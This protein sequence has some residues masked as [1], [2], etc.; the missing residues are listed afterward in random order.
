V[1]MNVMTALLA[2]LTLIAGSTYAA[3]QNSRREKIRQAVVKQYDANGNG[4]LDADEE[5]VILKKYDINGDGELDWDE[6]RTL[7]KGVA[8]LLRKFEKIE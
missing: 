8:G 6:K 1:K 4:K 5:A 3:D 2:G 7:A